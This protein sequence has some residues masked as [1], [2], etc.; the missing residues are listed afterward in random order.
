MSASKC[1]TLWGEPEFSDADN[2]HRRCP[3]I[4]AYSCM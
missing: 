3:E 1:N 4:R 2:N